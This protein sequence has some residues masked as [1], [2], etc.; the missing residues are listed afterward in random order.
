MASRLIL[1]YLADLLQSSKVGAGYVADDH[2]DVNLRRTSLSML[3]DGMISA[4]H[5]EFKAL[6]QVVQGAAWRLTGQ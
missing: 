6:M 1:V 4:R 2:N 5:P 3:L